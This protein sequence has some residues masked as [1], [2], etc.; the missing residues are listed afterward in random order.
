MSKFKTKDLAKLGAVVA[1]AGAGAATG[2]LAA[3]R[4]KRSA[5]EKQEK[6]AA[7]A[8]R[9]STYRNTERG[10]NARNSKG[11]YYS[12]G[13]YEAFARPEKPE[14]VDQ[15]SA[16][17]VGSGLASLAAA[18]F[19]VRDG[20]MKGENIHILEA[21]DIAGGACDGINDPTR[22]YVMR[23]GREME[24]H[25]ECLW[26]LF[27]S[28][29]S[30]EVPDAS[31]LDEYYWLNKHDP[32]YSLCRATVN[33][34]EDAHTDGQFH[35]SQK[36]CMEIMKL[37]FTPDEDLY[38]KTIED[39][40]DDEVF[41][42]DFWLYWRTMFAFENWHSALE[43][44]LYIQRFIHHIGGLP[45]FSALKF[46][47]YNQYESLILPMQKYLESHGVQFQFNTEVTN[48]IFDFDGEKKV[49]KKIVCKVNGVEQ[50]IELTENDL[51]FVTNGSCTEGTIYG[52]HTHAPVGDAEVRTSGCWSL[53]KNIAA[54]HPSFGHPE[55]FCGDIS[56]SNW[57]S[58]TITTDNE[59]IIQQIEKICKRDPRSGRVVTGGIVSCK[60]SSWLLSWTINRQ[61]QFKEQAKKD[62]CIWVYALFTDKPGDYV[63]KPMKECTGMEITQEWLYHLGVPVEHIDGLARHACN[64]TPTMMPYITAFFMPRRKGDRP[65]V[66]PDGS[67]N[68]AFLGQFAETPRDTIFTTEYSVRTAME[69]VY[70]LLGV[71]RGVPEVWG[72]VYD[73]R[74]LL[75]SSVKLMD[76]KSPLDVL[77]PALSPV[78]NLV[79]KKIHGT[80]I[81][82]LLKDHDVIR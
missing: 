73:V 17:L 56:R 44:K 71:D 70:G 29:P 22:G 79:L 81:E 60:D 46:T 47:K 75:D 55:K 4:A 20:Q 38:D 25:F 36:G 26:D 14:G 23:G 50:E 3:K 64:A 57:E 61:G 8:L 6:K 28:I 19:L 27:R 13:N 67:V 16:W 30:L 53:W 1:A 72:S 63:K 69:A 32:N 12:N 24:N 62:V 80:V 39:F 5:G 40:F 65:D 78:K 31:V 58:A 2:A 48:V 52:D 43:M 41:S 77:P 15:K 49:A 34:G 10:A 37:F 74:A 68:F 21:M 18:C 59:E 33:R 45:D 82:K 11:I 42:S 7:E 66:I 76:G 35:L 51:V 9:L 54:Q